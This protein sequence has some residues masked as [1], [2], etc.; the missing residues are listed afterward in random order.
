[1]WAKS[2]TGDLVHAADL[3]IDYVA[4]F[5]ETLER[6][7]DLVDLPAD[8]AGDFVQRGDLEAEGLCQGWLM[9]LLQASSGQ[10]SD[11]QSLWSSLLGRPDFVQPVPDGSVPY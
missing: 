6:A 5:V 1:M 9:Y 7:E 8:P 2:V 4:D 10:I 3:I 11:K